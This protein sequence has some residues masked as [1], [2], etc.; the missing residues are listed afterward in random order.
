MSQWGSQPI[1]A[2]LPSN[3]SFPTNPHASYPIESEIPNAIQPL[4]DLELRLFTKSCAD[5]MTPDVLRNEKAKKAERPWK[6]VK[7]FAAMKSDG[8]T[9]LTIKETE[10][11][12]RE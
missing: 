2:N 1:N 3:V 12:F 7:G 4:M 10:D 6:L 11:S 9:P 8:N 5:M